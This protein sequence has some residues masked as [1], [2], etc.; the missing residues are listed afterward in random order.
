MKVAQLPNGVELQFPDDTDDAV[1]DKAVKDQ[2]AAPPTS[3]GTITE[4]S[5]MRN[6]TE[7]IVNEGPAVGGGVAAGVAAT[8]I[9]GVTATVPLAGIVALGAGAGEAW[10]QIGQHMSGSLAAPKTSLEAAKRIAM[11]GVEQGVWEAVGG[12]AMKGVG[13]ILA[14]FKN[15][16]VEGATNVMEFFKD[17]IKPVVLLPAE[18]TESRALDLLNNISE[19]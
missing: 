4:N 10:K 13:K 11:L 17:R 7:G 16:M 8:G 19:A 15:K 14:P 2:M 1:M 6:I 12:L 9:A 18:A 3:P 5:T